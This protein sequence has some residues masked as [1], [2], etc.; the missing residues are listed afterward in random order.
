MEAGVFGVVDRLDVGD[1][2]V[3]DK[4]A[5]HN[6]FDIRTDRDDFFVVP[7]AARFLR[8]GFGGD[9]AV[10]GAVLLPGRDAFVIFVDNLKFHAVVGGVKI[11]GGGANAQ[12]VVSASIFRE[13]EFKSENEVRIRFFRFKVA[14]LFADEITVFDRVAFNSALPDFGGEFR[15]VEEQFES[16]FFFLIGQL[17]ER[18]TR[19]SFDAGDE[20]SNVDDK[21]RD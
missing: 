16:K 7:F 11:G 17:I 19:L 18:L 12:A 2:R 13:L 9:A 14:A 1:I 10:D 15:S 21:R 20:R 8:A 6:D 3:N 4:I 5:V